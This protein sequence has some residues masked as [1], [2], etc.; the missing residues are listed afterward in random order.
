[1]VVDLT[2][3]EQF[4]NTLDNRTFRWHGEQRVTSDELTSVEALSA[5]LA[6]HDLVTE[7]QQLRR[8][9]L[10]AAVA[11]RAALREA[12]D[13]DAKAAQLA[14]FPLRLTPDTEGRLRITADS[15]VPGLDRIVETVATS[16]AG[17]GWHRLKLCAAPDCRWAF[18]DTSRNGGGRWCSMEACGNRTKTRAYRRRAD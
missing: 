5:W 7:G 14:D 8:S 18:Y 2:L 17:G 9:D 3:V 15:G 13:D 1:V 6:A 4:L 10:A 11:L 12:L 16:V